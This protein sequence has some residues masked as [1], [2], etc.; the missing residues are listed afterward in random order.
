MSVLLNGK[1][2]S[3]TSFRHLVFFDLSSCPHILPSSPIRIPSLSIHSNPHINL[4]LLVNLVSVLFCNI[5]NV[6]LWL[7]MKW[8]LHIHRNFALRGVISARQIISS[9]TALIFP[10]SSM[11][12]IIL[13]STVESLKNWNCLSIALPPKSQGIIINLLDVHSYKHAFVCGIAT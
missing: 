3:F 12:L 1:L 5:G 13:L 10:V 2:N 7:S 8:I 4:K 9:Y 11:S 6:S